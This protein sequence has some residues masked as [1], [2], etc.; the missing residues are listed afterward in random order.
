MINNGVYRKLYFKKLLAKGD[1]DEAYAK[2]LKENYKQLSE[3]EWDN[4]MVIVKKV[5][6]SEAEFT[7]EDVK[8]CFDV[9]RDVI[10]KDE[11]W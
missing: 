2:A 4:Y 6:F 5:A 10:Y 9:F 8:F 3:E 7:K 11:V 1:G